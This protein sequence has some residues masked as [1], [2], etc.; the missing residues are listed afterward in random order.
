MVKDHLALAYLVPW[1]VLT[2]IAISMFIQGWMICHEAMG[3]KENPK[4][5][6]RYRH[7]E[8]LDYKRGDGLLVVNFQDPADPDYKLLQQRIS[9]LSDQDPETD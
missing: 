6:L 9:D 8:M 1:F 5:P 2:G 7:P 3:Y 4:L